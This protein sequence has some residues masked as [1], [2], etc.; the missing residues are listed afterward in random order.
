MLEIPDEVDLAVIVTP[1]PT[2]PRIMSECVAK[3]VRAAIVISGGFSEA[4][5]DGGAKLEK[6]VKNAAQGRVKIP[7]ITD[8]S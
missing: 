1:A 3:G 5:E 8:V 6:E 2:V 7:L 4:G